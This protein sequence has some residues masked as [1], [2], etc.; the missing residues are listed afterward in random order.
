MLKLYPNKSK[1]LSPPFWRNE[2]VDK[3]FD[4]A[5]GIGLFLE[6][7]EDRIESRDIVTELCQDYHL[8]FKAATQLCHYLKSQ[9]A[10]TQKLPHRHRLLFE[11]TQAKGNAAQVGILHAHW[12]GRV[13]RPLGLFLTEVWRK[14]YHQVLSFSCSDDCLMLNF[15]KPIEG[16][17]IFDIFKEEKVEHYLTSSLENSD[18]FGA[19]FRENAAHSFLLPKLN[20]KIRMPLW[21]LRRNA[22]ELL[23]RV[24]Q[25]NDFP[26]L[27]ETWRCCFEDSFDLNALKRVLSEVVEGRIA[28]EIVHTVK[29]SPFAADL[30]YRNVSK[31]M[32]EDDRPLSDQKISLS[33][34]VL[35]EVMQS[36][37]QRPSIEQSILIQ[38][39]NKLQRTEPGYEP[40]SVMELLDSL[41]ERIFLTELQWKDIVKITEKNHALFIKESLSKLQDEA[42]W[43]KYRESGEWLLC[44]KKNFPR[45]LYAFE[46]KF[47]SLLVF[48]FDLRPEKPLKEVDDNLFEGLLPCEPFSLPPD[49]VL[50]ELVSDFVSFYSC[51]T[52]EELCPFFS[53]VAHKLP[54]VIQTLITQN[55]LVQGQLVKGREETVLI[56]SRNYERA[57]YLQRSV[58]MIHI[59]YKIKDLSLFLAHWHQLLDSGEKSLRDILEQCFGYSIDIEL[60][61]SCIFPF[62]MNEYTPFQLDEI[63]E[64]STLKWVGCGKEKVYF[65]MHEE[66]ELFVDGENTELLKSNDIFPDQRGQYDFYDLMDANSLTSSELSEQ[67]WEMCWK[68]RCVSSGMK[69][70]RQG[71]LTHFKTPKVNVLKHSKT[72]N[73]WKSNCPTQGVWQQLTY[74]ISKD[75]LE[76]LDNLKHKVNILLCRYGVIFKEILK[77]EM[78]AFNWSKILTALRLMEMSGE[79]LSGVFFTQIQGL[80]FASLEAVQ[81]LKEMADSNK[82]WC[83]NACDPISLCGMGLVEDVQSVK[84]IK[85]N[86]LIYSG[87][88]LII[89]VK[90][91]G[92]EIV[93]S[94]ITEQRILVQ[95]LEKLK[96]IIRIQTKKR[97][98][99]T[100]EIINHLAAKDS[101]YKDI[102]IEYGFCMVNK[103][104]QLI[105]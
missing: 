104:L 63:I 47:E 58:N 22:K 11:L 28:F 60:W 81:C 13:L 37:N 43:F 4:T 29:T 75:A 88:K 1:S 8:Q 76:D 57:L 93:I 85:S 96:L 84:R 98:Y 33:E 50:Y 25:F 73:R 68:G 74:S 77:Y 100:I 42:L 61:E 38:F 64:N 69:V 52:L 59:N 105:D 26:I 56:S 89:F 92:R 55:R 40:S 49:Q 99:V 72:F 80:Q 101:T 71:L 65:C 17:E 70:L 83:I 45:L 54:G 31:L 91:H 21:V 103:G 39:K 94:E 24:R 27:A 36:E 78:P 9:I 15:P 62:R 35:A 48:P 53:I 30:M 19:R 10:V 82:V 23:L 6:S 32:Y 86:W 95:C 44:L 34:K 90:S 97:K 18:F 5:E 16:S 20:P 79:V 2:S 46:I 87:S 51:I 7:I 12:G 3:D 14:K 41:D 66:A 67:L 102:L